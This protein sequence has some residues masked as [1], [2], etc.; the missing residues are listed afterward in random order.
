[1]GAVATTCTPPLVF[2]YK[3]ESGLHTDFQFQDQL[4]II[5][6][7]S[8]LLCMEQ[9]TTQLE[10]IIVQHNTMSLE[11]NATMNQVDSFQKDIVY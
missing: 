3:S 8:A 10:C 7:I 5:S 9:D 6:R 11:I 1:L 2:G 4:N